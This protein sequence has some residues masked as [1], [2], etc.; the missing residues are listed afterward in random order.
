M[1]FISVVA[2]DVAVVYLPLMPVPFY[3]LLK[4]RGFRLVEVPD[5]EFATMGPNVLLP[6]NQTMLDGNPPVTK[7]RLEAAGCRGTNLSRRRN[8]AQS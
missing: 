1:S 3:Q 7:Q 6:G 5:E 8:L 2:E 4:A